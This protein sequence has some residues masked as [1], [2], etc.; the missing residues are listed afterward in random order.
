[1]AHLVV[2]QDGPT[3]SGSLTL[4][5]G[6]AICMANPLL[7]YDVAICIT[8]NSWIGEGHSK[9]P[10]H[11]YVGDWAILCGPPKLALRL[12]NLWH[13]VWLLGFACEWNGTW[14]HPFTPYT[15]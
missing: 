6:E 1:M 11:T 4:L 12:H 5:F 3:S 7:V 15:F 2:A 13:W 8:V 9:G 10:T 14:S